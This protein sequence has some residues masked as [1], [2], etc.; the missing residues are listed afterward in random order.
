MDMNKQLPYTDK[1][2]EFCKNNI[3]LG[4]LINEMENEPEEQQCKFI[5][6]TNKHKLKDF[7]YS[8]K[9]AFDFIY[10]DIL[11]DKFGVLLRK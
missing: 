10:E 9:K 2:I 6:Y 1:D 7:V 11:Y 4:R 5:Y 3:L 8:V